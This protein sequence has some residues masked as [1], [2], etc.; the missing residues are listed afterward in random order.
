MINII[1]LCKIGKKEKENLEVNDKKE[2]EEQAHLLL[3]TEICTSV[4]KHLY[5]VRVTLHGSVVHR[6]V[7]SLYIRKK[8]GLYMCSVFEKAG[9]TY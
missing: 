4:G 2:T 1:V 9:E 8:W 3:S 5:D 7:S 6:C